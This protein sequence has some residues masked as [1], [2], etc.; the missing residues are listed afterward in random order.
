MAL[1]GVMRSIGF[2]AARGKLYLPVDLL[3]AA[4]LA[5]DEV[6]AGRG[7]EKRAA[8][9]GAESQSGRR[10]RLENARASAVGALP[11]FLPAALVPLYLRWSHAP[12]WRRQLTMIGAAWRGSL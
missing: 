12:L 7:G 4:G 5:P 9:P 3:C 1:C 8:G 6:L 11:A 10:L 2:H